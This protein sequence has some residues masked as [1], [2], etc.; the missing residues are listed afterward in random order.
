MEEDKQAV[1]PAQELSSFTL[2]DNPVAEVDMSVHQFEI[3]KDKGKEFI[4][5]TGLEKPKRKKKATPIT[6]KKP[7][8]KRNTRDPIASPLAKE[9]AA[10]KVP[11]LRQPSTVQRDGGDR[12]TVAGSDVSDSR[13]Q[14]REGGAQKTLNAQLAVVASQHYQAQ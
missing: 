4:V 13:I 7:P 3:G 11:R 1:P 8:T 9:K 5:D 12:K 14:Q 2:H 6:P 10:P